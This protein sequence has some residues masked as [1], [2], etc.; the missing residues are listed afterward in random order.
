MNTLPVAL[1]IVAA[2]SNNLENN[3]RAV[4]GLRK[5]IQNPLTKTLFHLT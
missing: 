1:L 2:F 5:H 3:S 4:M